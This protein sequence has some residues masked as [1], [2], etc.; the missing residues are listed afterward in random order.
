VSPD[1]GAQGNAFN[2]FV[3]GVQ[4]AIAQDAKSA[5]HLVDPQ[6]ALAVAMARQ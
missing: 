4:L 1:Y 6:Q 2:G 3:R 5:D